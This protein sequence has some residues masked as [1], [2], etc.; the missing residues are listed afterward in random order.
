MIS[1]YLLIIYLCSLSTQQCNSGMVTGYSFPDHYDCAM[2][3]YEFAQDT[4]KKMDRELVNKDLLAIKFECKQV[5]VS[6]T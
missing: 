6:K 3:G 2:K 5:Q 1:K 4:I